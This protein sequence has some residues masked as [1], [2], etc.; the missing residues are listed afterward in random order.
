MAFRAAPTC[1][2]SRCTPTASGWS[3]GSPA[4]SSIPRSTRWRGVRTGS[5]CTTPATSRRRRTWPTATRARAASS[6]AAWSCPAPASSTRC[7]GSP[8]PTHAARRCCAWPAR[9]APR[10][11]TRGAACSTRSRT[12]SRCCDRSSSGP[13]GPPGPTRSRRWLPRPCARCGPAGRG[14]PRSRC[15]PTSWRPRP[16]PPSRR[17]SSTAGHRSTRAG[18]RRSRA[19]CTAPTVR[20]SSPA[21]ACCSQARGRSWPTWPSA[22]TRPSCSARTRRA[23]C[24][25]VTAW[26]STARWRRISSRTRT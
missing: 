3:S 5:A 16:G 13:A 4:S 6:A 21:A 11:S 17:S 25:L 7:P 20:S 9:S 22:W 10:T 23:R 24:R 14:R 2:W 18:S 15:R 26:H 19:C 8:R 1:W 12:S